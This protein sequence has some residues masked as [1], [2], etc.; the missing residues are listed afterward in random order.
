MRTAERTHRECLATNWT[1]RFTMS[2][3]N[4]TTDYAE[5]DAVST[6]LL[7]NMGLHRKDHPALVFDGRDDEDFT[8]FCKDFEIWYMYVSK[9]YGK[10]TKKSRECLSV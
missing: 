5:L 7:E 6:L 10:N 9:V 3:T 8:N 1:Q 4:T 2:T